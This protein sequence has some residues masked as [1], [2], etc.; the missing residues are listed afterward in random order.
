[1]RGRGVKVDKGPVEDGLYPGVVHYLSAGHLHDQTD[2]V[3]DIHP[4][5]NVER[6]VIVFV[7]ED[8]GGEAAEKEGAGTQ[9]GKSGWVGF[10]DGFAVGL[11]GSG[12][13][14]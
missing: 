10:F 7:P 13:V 11:K 8:F 1:M 2:A 5:Y 9:G 6:L 12:A 4:I 3:P 14:D